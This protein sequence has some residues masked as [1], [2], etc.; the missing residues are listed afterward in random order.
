MSEIP[1]RLHLPIAAG[2]GSSAVRSRSTWEW[3]ATF[4]LPKRHTL[5]CAAATTAHSSPASGKPAYYVQDVDDIPGVRR[6]HIQDPFG[7]RIELID[8]TSK[9][10][11]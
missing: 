8:S 4:A 5:P 2:A 3:R 1:S 10:K 11:V 6:C 7:N 9:E